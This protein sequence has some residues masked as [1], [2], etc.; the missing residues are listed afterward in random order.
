MSVQIIYICN[1]IIRIFGFNSILWLF[2]FYLYY[3]SFGSM[4]TF[5]AL[6]INSIALVFWLSFFFFLYVCSRVYNNNGQLSQYVFYFQCNVIP[7]HRIVLPTNP[8]LSFVLLLSHIL[9]LHIYKMHNTFKQPIIFREILRIRKK[10]YILI[11]LV[12]MF[13]ISS[14][15]DFFV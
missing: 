8:P 5:L 2:A 3:L 13:T 9:F 12:P 1:E 11:F 7:Y 4:L 15:L 10:V 14:V 6:L